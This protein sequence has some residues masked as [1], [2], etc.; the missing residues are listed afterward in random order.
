MRCWGIAVSGWSWIWSGG[1]PAGAA[2]GVPGD[3]GVFGPDTEVWRIGRERLLLAAGPAAVLLQLAH[4][5]VAAGVA[6]HSG[7]RADP[8]RRLRATLDATLA[9][10]FGDRAQAAAAT[11]RVGALHRHVTGRTVTTVGRFPAG[12]PYRADDPQLSLWVHATLVWTALEWY[13]RAIAP[14]PASRRARYQAE[15]DRFGRLFGVPEDLLPRSYGQFEAYVRGMDE[16]GVLEVGP[17]ARAMAGAVLASRA[18]AIPAPLKPGADSLIG[19]LAAGLLPARL[20]AGYRLPWGRREQH[21]FAAACA[22]G[23]TAAPVLPA[24]L[25]YWPHYLAAQRRVR[26]ENISVARGIAGVPPS[27]RS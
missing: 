6:E 25:R 21:A 5:L 23:R 3:P 11:A 15:M 1:I 12:T 18:W 16:E 26:A 10:T 22:A 7:F 4:P 2:A 17:P 9:V 14:L 20:R 19:I 27:R 13:G 8:T 24:R